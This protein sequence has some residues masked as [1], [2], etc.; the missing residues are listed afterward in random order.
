MKVQPTNQS[1]LQADLSNYLDTLH[2]INRKDAEHQGLRNLIRR[3]TIRPA[4]WSNSIVLSGVQHA[5]RWHSALAEYGTSAIPLHDVYLVSIP[6]WAWTTSSRHWSLYSQG[7]FFHLV[8]GKDGPHLK[9]DTLTLEKIRSELDSI[10][11][12]VRCDNVHRMIAHAAR[13]RHIPLV[14]Y[15]IGQTQFNVAQMKCLAE[16]I[17]GTFEEYTKQEKNCH[18][19]VLSLAIRVLMTKGVGTIFVGTRAQIAYW[20]ITTSSGEQS[21]PY[22]QEEG[23]LL[24]AP[25]HG[26]SVSLG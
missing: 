15:N 20:D 21:T 4:G 24:R 22:C 14:A 19:F 12:Q 3:I 11:W 2:D 16:F 6:E 10:Q 18:L 1:I 9:I 7:S 23:F 17:C 5:I 25:S 8:T 26:R 13:D